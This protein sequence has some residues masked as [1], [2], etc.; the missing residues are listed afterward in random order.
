MIN[1]KTVYV[2]IFAGGIGSRMG[3]DIPKQFLKVDNK[4]IIIHTLEKF[5]SHP[6]VDAIVVVSKREYVEFCKQ[7]IIANGIKKVCEITS[8]GETGQESIYNGLAALKNIG[9]KDDDIVIIHDGVRPVITEQLITDSIECTEKNGNSIAT[10]RAI[11]TVIRVDKTG[12]VISTVDRSEC[13]N[14]KAPQCFLFG[15]IWDAHN[16]ALVDGINTMID[17]ATL[18]S[19]YGFQLHT[20][21]CSANNIKITTPVDYYLFKALNDVLKSNHTL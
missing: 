16:R 5:D 14:A 13:R 17:S 1:R 2:V 7:I 21:E 8:G 15:D 19:H 6:L 18:M 4:E 3:S 20:T 9:S 10:S 11:E 12:N